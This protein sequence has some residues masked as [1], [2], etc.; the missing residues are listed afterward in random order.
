[1]VQGFFYGAVILIAL[2]YYLLIGPQGS[3]SFFLVT[4]S[5]LLLSVAVFVVRLGR[6]A[7]TRRWPQVVGIIQE[8]EPRRDG[9]RLFYT[10]RVNDTPYQNDVYDAAA[11]LAH[12]VALALR[13]KMPRITC[14]DLVNRRVGVYFDPDEPGRSVLS[15]SGLPC[16]WLLLL[17]ALASMCSCGFL[18]YL[19]VNENL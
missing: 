12:P 14:D 1:M 6:I 18:I 11:P 2:A 3:I 17:P 8:V 19:L 10:Y 16:P 15:R 4:I 5:V 9:W 13:Y 7:R